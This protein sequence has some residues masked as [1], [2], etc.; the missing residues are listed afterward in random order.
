MSAIA[1]GA[2]L[3]GLGDLQ[4]FLTLDAAMQASGGPE[5]EPRDA[6]TQGG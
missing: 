5:E 6:F 4:T 1:A 2:I 3:D